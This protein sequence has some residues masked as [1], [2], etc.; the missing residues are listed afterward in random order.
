MFLALF[1]VMLKGEKLCDIPFE[2]PCI[3]AKQR[4]SKYSFV[5]AMGPD[6]EGGDKG[7][8]CVSLVSLLYDVFG[9]LIFMLV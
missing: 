5:W 4:G 6:P 7:F 1:Q 2:N 9:F 3:N 8:V